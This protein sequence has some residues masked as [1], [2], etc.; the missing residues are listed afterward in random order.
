MSTITSTPMLTPPFAPGPA[1]R[2][3]VD[4]Y[5]RMIVAGVLEDPGKV[6]LIDGTLVEKMAKSAKHGYSTM[7][8]IRAFDGLLPPGWSWRTEQPVRIPDY[9]EP[10]PDVAIVRGTYRDYRDRIPGVGDVGLLVEISLTTLAQ[11]MGVK[12]LAYAKGAIPIYWI[13]NLV[14][15]QVEVY[16]DPGPG[17]YR[18]HQVL[19]PGHALS[20]VIDGVEIGAIPV[21]DILP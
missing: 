16:S 13:V 20:V 1:H 8:L 19:A 2:F 17:G 11:D 21:S 18:S 7:G 14:D 6:E 3:T 15:G 12:L 10:E 5:E 4:E 9:D